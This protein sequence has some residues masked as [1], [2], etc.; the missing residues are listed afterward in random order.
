MRRWAGVQSGDFRGGTAIVLEP[1]GHVRQTASITAGD[2][3]PC[4]GDG[5]IAPGKNHPT[6]GNLGAERFHSIAI[7]SSSNR[8]RVGH[9][10]GVSIVWLSLFITKFVPWEKKHPRLLGLLHVSFPLVLL[11][12][13]TIDG[14]PLFLTLG[15]RVALAPSHD[16]CGCK[17]GNLRL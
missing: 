2:A 17:N 4:R 5:L 7:R 11:A 6:L 15:A 16:A 9:A 1:N 10:F 14:E 12:A 8:S 13:A 3:N